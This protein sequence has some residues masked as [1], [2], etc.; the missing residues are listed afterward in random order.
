SP[1][2]HPIAASRISENTHR[3]PDF[4]RRRISENSHGP[5]NIQNSLV[6]IPSPNPLV[7]HPLS[8]E[9]IAEKPDFTGLRVDRVGRL[10][11]RP[12]EIKK[13]R[14]SSRGSHYKIPRVVIQLI[15]SIDS[16]PNQPPNLSLGL[17]ACFCAPPR[18]SAGPLPLIFLH[19]PGCIGCRGR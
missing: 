14:I 16:R 2:S 7:G 3:N 11:I 9:G 17:G 4:G 19:S 15:D 12:R 13:T 18:L 1:S 6:S 5:Q 8:P 10:Y